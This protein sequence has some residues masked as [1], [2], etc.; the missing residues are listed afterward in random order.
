MGEFPESDQK[1]LDGVPSSGQR[2]ILNSGP[3]FL[4]ESFKLSATDSN[5][6]ADPIFRDSPHLYHF[7]PWDAN[8]E[9]VK[10]AVMV[11][12]PILPLDYYLRN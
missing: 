3:T 7:S 4:T 2:I 6:L 8:Y 1:L 9:L 12:G 10:A 5:K 11:D